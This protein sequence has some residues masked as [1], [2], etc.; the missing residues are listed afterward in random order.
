MTLDTRALDKQANKLA[1][2]KPFAVMERRREDEQRAR[3]PVRTGEPAVKINTRGHF[4]KRFG[5]T[6]LLMET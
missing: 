5:H 6:P 1:K 3:D 4:S 2:D